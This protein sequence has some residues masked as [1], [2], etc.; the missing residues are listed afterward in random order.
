MV[1]ENGIGMYLHD[2]TQGPRCAIACAPVRGVVVVMMVVVMVANMC[3]L[4]AVRVAIALG[5]RLIQ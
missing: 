1:P 4:F 2:P 5:L 3:K